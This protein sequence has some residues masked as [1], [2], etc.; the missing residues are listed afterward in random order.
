MEQELCEMCEK[1]PATI[2]AIIET[3]PGSDDTEIVD[4][5]MCKECSDDYHEFTRWAA[6]QKRPAMGAI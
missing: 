3:M 4:M 2:P 1:H 6:K 5:K